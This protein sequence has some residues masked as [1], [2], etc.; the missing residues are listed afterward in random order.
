MDRL[1]PGREI[2]VRLLSQR[3]QAFDPI[4]LIAQLQSGDEAG[5]DH[6]QVGDARI[7]FQVTDVTV[8]ITRLRRK[9]ALR[10]LRAFA[11]VAQ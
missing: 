9:V 6:G 2:L 7:V 8:M 10:Q 1:R 5:F 11:Q 3:K 4:L